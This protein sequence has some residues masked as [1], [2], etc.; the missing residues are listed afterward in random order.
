HIVLSRRL[1]EG[2][3][4]PAI[5][6]E[7]SISRVMPQVTDAR[8]YRLARRFKELWANYMQ[9]RDLISVGAYTRGSNPAVDQAIALYPRLREFLMQGMDEQVRYADGLAQ[10]AAVL[11]ES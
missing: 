9:H 11:G 1:A 7:A 8:Q 5:D 3:Q 6:I 10:L 4:Y 2:G